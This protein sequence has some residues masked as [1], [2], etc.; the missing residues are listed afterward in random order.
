MNL[1]NFDQSKTNL[2]KAL[3]KILEKYI[4]PNSLN[5]FLEDIV[6]ILADALINGNSSINLNDNPPINLKTKGWPHAHIQALI[7]SGWLEGDS[8][9]IILE[10]DQLSWRR[11]HY[12]INEII[13]TLFQKIKIKSNRI[14]E[15]I[16]NDKQ[17][18]HSINKD[19]YASIEIIRQQDLVL[20]SGG[21]GTGKTKTIIEMII[22]L[23]SF[24]NNMNIGLAAPT[25]KA[26][27]RL[28]DALQANIK[29]SNIS[30][31][32]CRTLHSWL[33]ASPSGFRKNKNS[34]L[35]LDLLVIDEMSMVSISLMQ[36]VLNALPIKSKLILVGDTNQLS[37]VGSIGIWQEIQKKN[38]IKNFNNISINLS[39]IYRNRG[40][41][42]ELSKIIKEKGLKSF[43]MKASCLKDS[44]NVK[45][46]YSSLNIIP[47]KI[48]NC[49]EEEKKTLQNL[50]KLLKIE[51]DNETN[52][53]N[54][55]EISSNETTTKIFESLENF[56]IL[57]PRK[58]G[59]WSTNHVHQTLLGEKFY[60]GV[61]HW[62]EA[63]PII[64]TEN[65]PE[66]GLSNG[67]IGLVI[68]K[69]HNRRLLF[70]IFSENQRLVCCLIHPAR[71]QNIEPA[72]ALTIHKAQG[73]EAKTV[74]V[75]W[76]DSINNSS[77]I[78]I[79]PTQEIFNK[80]LLYTAITRA[81]E[82]LEINI[83][84]EIHISKSS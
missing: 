9:P 28:N 77:I 13:E 19:Q 81:K 23:T 41:I 66:L 40:E 64:C 57:C 60:K 38:V 53:S 27:R 32:Q 24:N 72:L 12:E 30:N 7:N 50:L 15:E 65:H 56:M 76:P 45:L 84:N 62:E 59:N 33:K 22:G 73:S 78:K 47:R 4:P 35:N 34:P 1:E 42:V 26:A 54:T 25:G 68:G 20:L 11:W 37:P 58:N 36:G 39:K 14:K 67:D 6:L 70:R 55:K 71:L 80:R 44:S 3:I 82:S 43:W 31:I 52:L 2:A 49:L 5:N 8:A 51:H 16:N 10:D 29:S 21:P 61:M 74:M 48:I 17:K 69:S 18:N 46:I 63:T 79:S 83:S 75:L